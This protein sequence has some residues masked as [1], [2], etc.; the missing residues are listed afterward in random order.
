MNRIVTIKN[1]ADDLDQAGLFVSFS[2][3]AGDADLSVEISGLTFNSREVSEGFLFICKGAHFRDEY[4]EDSIRSGAACFVK[5]ENTAS[6]FRS[7][8]CTGIIV[9]DI[10]KAMP[11]IAETYYGKLSDHLHIVGITG[12][13]GKST[14]AYFMRYILDDYMSDIGKPRTAINSS[15]ENYDGVISE[16]SRLTTPEILDLYKRMNNAVSSGIE[17]LTMELSSQGLKYDRVDGIEFDA[18]AFLNIGRD[19]ISDIEHPDFDDYLDSKLKI[20]RLCRKACYNLDCDQQER[21]KK[22]SANCPYVI[23]FS[24]FD[25]S[26]NVYGYDV[27]SDEGRVSFRARVTGVSGVDDFDEDF[28]L[29]T[30][31][32]INVEDALAAISLSSLLKVPVKY[33]KSGLAKA[34]VPG[35]MEVFRSKDG[36]RIAVV[37][38]AHNNISYEKFF[39]TMK[40]EFPGRKIMIV[41]GS[42]GGKAFARRKDLGT[43]A[44]KNCVY[45][46]LTEDDPA[47]EDIYKICN[48]LGG[49]LTEQGCPY[50]IVPI[51]TEAIERAIGLMEDNMI[52]FI[53]GKGR[54]T[55]QRRG[56]IYYDTL[57]DADVVQKFL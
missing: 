31:G 35:R 27:V 36:K 15:I 19:H 29:G 34:T 8:E 53:P 12:T 39:Q 30:F 13:K 49:Y 17:Y 41:F 5:E 26:A 16:E 2:G 48:E 40:D 44:G 18:C 43:I 23:T 51:R 10:R 47:E 25:S 14:T 1:I 6:D 24:N 56:I 54:E 46:V 32:T 21:I 20:F 7:D 3:P 42:S 4:L 9:N 22:A 28:T 50:E 52:L 45:A 55:R 11:V 38:Y 37:D 33:M 57:S